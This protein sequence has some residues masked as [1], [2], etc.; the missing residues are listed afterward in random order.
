MKRRNP[1]N[2]S[3]IWDAAI[4]ID[5]QC[6]DS[7]HHLLR[8][9]IRL[10]LNFDL[11]KVYKLYLDR[12]LKYSSASVRTLLLLLTSS[13]KLDP[14]YR[15][16]ILRWLVPHDEHVIESISGTK[17]FWSLDHDTL[18]KCF[19]ALMVPP[20]SMHHVIQELKEIETKPTSSSSKINTI[21]F[22]NRL[23][24]SVHLV[25]P[26]KITEKKQDQVRTTCQKITLCSILKEEIKDVLIQLSG[27]IMEKLKNSSTQQQQQQQ[28]LYM[29][30]MA[31][32]YCHL[33]DLIYVKMQSI[34]L[35]FEEENRFENVIANLACQALNS[36]DQVLTVKSLHMEKLKVLLQSWNMF[37]TKK[38][39]N[40]CNAIF[41]KY[42]K[43]LVQ[44]SNKDALFGDCQVN[45]AFGEDKEAKQLAMETVQNLSRVVGKGVSSSN[46]HQI[47]EFTECLK[48]FLD[49]IQPPIKVLH[50]ITSG[51]EGLFSV[52]SADGGQPKFDQPILYRIFS[53]LQSLVKVLFFNYQPDDFEKLMSWVALCIENIDTLAEKAPLMKKNALTFVHGFLSVQS[54]R[55]LFSPK[56]QISLVFCIAKLAEKDLHGTWANFT[57]KVYQMASHE[58]DYDVVETEKIP[59][60]LLLSKFTRNPCQLV[61]DEAI[62]QFH[63]IV[64][65]LPDIEFKRLLSHLTDTMHEWR[66]VPSQEELI[67]A[68]DQTTNILASKLNVFLPLLVSL[69][70]Y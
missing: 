35:R 50:I 40:E 41:L 64:P 1:K 32:N 23:L 29:I 15:L 53:L 61:R 17:W 2:S 54:T 58:E 10:E 8:T 57:L 65:Q 25:L 22:E 36:L 3:V 55:R 12:R 37:Q 30:Q 19:V 59:S 45:D 56:V 62:K 27:A 9:M 38:I 21:T 7:G 42:L 69:S 63:R 24:E 11:D 5:N 47:V 4:N 28:P 20:K 34:A 70:T 52:A 48:S 33:L 46:D 31:L 43:L 44:G 14:E 49:E 51:L 66:Y 6:I 68:H 13:K 18:S 67:E 60:Y 16:S 26:I 39:Q